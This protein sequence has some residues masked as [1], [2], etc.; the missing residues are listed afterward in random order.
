MSKN[1]AALQT[2][3]AGSESIPSKNL[4]KVHGKPLFMYSI[5]AAKESNKISHVYCSTD[6]VEIIAASENEQFRYIQRP[7]HLCG[8]DA[9]HLETIRHGVLEIEKETGKLDIVVLLLGNVVGINGDALDDAIDMIADADSVVS[10]S[11]FNMFNPFRVH[12]IDDD[13]LLQTWAKQSDIQ[14]DINVNDKDSAGDTYYCN[15]NFWIMKRDVIFDND[16]NL[17]FR[18]LGKKIV[19]YI[20]RP[21]LELDAP[22][23]I[24]LL[25]KAAMSDPRRIK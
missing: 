6:D 9:D 16:N 25:A 15:G 7:R 21:F 10:V 18:W 2:A 3:R 14:S 17:P 20:Q 24:S 11:E 22:W 8:S 19:P 23:Q 5:E 4:L 1:I 12:Q 13:G